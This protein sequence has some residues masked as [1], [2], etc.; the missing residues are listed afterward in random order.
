MTDI[1]N[2]STV[3]VAISNY[4]AVVTMN[5]P[6]VNAQNRQFHDDLTLAFDVLS[7]RNDGGPSSSLVP[8]NVS[9]PGLILRD[10]RHKI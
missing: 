9:Q 3:N 7:D 2:L 10:V 4:I 8:E 5:N 1:T 6:P